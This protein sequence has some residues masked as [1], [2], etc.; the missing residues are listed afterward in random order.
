MNKST[1]SALAVGV[2]GIAAIG[3]SY[4]KC[5]QPHELTFAEH[6]YVWASERLPLT[7]GGMKDP[8]IAEAVKTWNRAAGCDVFAYSPLAPEPDVLVVD[9][10]VSPGEVRADGTVDAE[11]AFIH[12]KPGTPTRGLIEIRNVSDPTKRYCVIAHGLGHIL[13]LAHDRSGMMGAR[14]LEHCDELPTPFVTNKDADAVGAQYCN[15]K[16]N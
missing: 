4:E 2:L 6:Q 11:R 15:P 13:D 9:V 14:L 3:I 10:G 12:V 7:V 8:A 16:E 5:V 1:I